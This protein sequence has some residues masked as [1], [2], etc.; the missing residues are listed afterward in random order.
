MKKII[1]VIKPFEYNQ[2]LLVY[3][4]GNKIDICETSIDNLNNSIFALMDKHNV[5]KLDFAGPR[6]YLQ[7]L[8][9]QITE[10]AKVKY[11]NQDIEI[12]II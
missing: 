11:T 6:K 8:S 10:K 4:D 12:N 9:N 2:T 3:E 1:G 7:G 5:Y